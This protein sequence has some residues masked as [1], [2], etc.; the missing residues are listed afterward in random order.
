MTINR[1]WL[2][3]TSE[4]MR[5]WITKEQ[6]RLILEQFGT[7]PEPYEWSEQDIVIQI[8]NFLGCGEFVKAIKDN[9]GEAQILSDVEF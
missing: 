6:E 9:S 7:E 1:R 3:K 4:S 5:V 2:K 8:Q